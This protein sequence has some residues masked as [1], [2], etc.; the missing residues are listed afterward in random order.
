MTR[1]RRKTKCPM[2]GKVRFRDHK[3]AAIARAR[4]GLARDY[5]CAAC[6]GYH[7]TSLA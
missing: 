6:K 5:Y 4:T 2:S 1:K 3:E 7:L